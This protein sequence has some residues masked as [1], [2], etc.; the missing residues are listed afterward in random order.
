MSRYQA[1]GLQLL[2]LCFLLPCLGRDIKG[3]INL[4]SFTLDKVVATHTVLVR[5]DRQHAYGEQEEVFKDLALHLGGLSTPNDFILAYVGVQEYQDRLNKDMA[6]KRFGITKDDWPTYRLFFRGK[7]DHPIIY[8]GPVTLQGLLG[9][10]REHAGISPSLPGTVS[11]LDDIAREFMSADAIK[12]LA[13]LETAKS[14][15]DGDDEDLASVYFKIMQKVI[16]DG[17]EVVEQDLGKTKK[18]LSSNLSKSR[19]RKEQFETRINVL[20]SF[21]VG[22]SLAHEEL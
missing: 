20:Q 5:F 21:R 13:L 16:E 6:E 14:T 11:N 10:L 8:D 22:S 4:D 17:D 1:Q 2:S 12:R 18:L 9:F 7:P 19:E 3:A 15:V